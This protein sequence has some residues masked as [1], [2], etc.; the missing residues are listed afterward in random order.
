MNGAQGYAVTTTGAGGPLACAA[1]ARNGIKAKSSMQAPP[2]QPL[3]H[4][5][6]RVNGQ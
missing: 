2:A 3:R 5:A 6:G 4:P 1:E